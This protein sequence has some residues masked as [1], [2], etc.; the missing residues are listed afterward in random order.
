MAVRREAV[1]RRWAHRRPWHSDPAP[2]INSNYTFYGRI[3]SG[4]GERLCIRRGSTDP[5]K[6]MRRTAVT[7][8]FSDNHS[9]P[10]GDLM[11]GALVPISTAWAAGIGGALE[12]AA[13]NHELQH[14]AG[15]TPATRAENYACPGTLRANVQVSQQRLHPS[16]PSLS[17]S[18]S[19]FIS[20]AKALVSLS[21][22][23]RAAMEI[24]AGSLWRKGLAEIWC[25]RVVATASGRSRLSAW[26]HARA[27]LARREG[28]AWWCNEWSHANVTFG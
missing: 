19:L 9:P 5:V 27:S 18:L 7:P 2:N 13:T 22:A 17:L 21:V 4:Q 3:R 6:S 23:R 1:P 26:P 25:M 12:P 28:F 11:D 14:E 16:L 10:A 20:N 24:E 15:H 8:G